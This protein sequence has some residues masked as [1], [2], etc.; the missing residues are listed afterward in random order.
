MVLDCRLVL[1]DQFVE[2][3]FQLGDLFFDLC[4]VGFELVGRERECD[5]FSH[6]AWRFEFDGQ[7]AEY[8][9]VGGFDLLVADGGRGADGV[10]LVFVVA[11]PHGVLAGSV[12]CPCFSSV[13][14]AAVGAFEA[15]GEKT[16]FRAAIAAVACGELDLGLIPGGGIDDRLVMSCDVVLRDFAFVDLRGLGEEVG[17]NGLLD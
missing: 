10:C 2:G 9:K 16:G 8:F 11:L 1:G 12:R 14:V 13:P 4:D 7:F 17:D 6:L 3:G 15:A 5:C